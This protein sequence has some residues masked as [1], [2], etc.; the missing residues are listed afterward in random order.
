MAKQNNPETVEKL[1]SKIK[2]CRGRELELVAIVGHYARRIAEKYPATK[3]HFDDMEADIIA[4]TVDW[5]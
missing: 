1:K 3:R 5:D 4:L 2:Q